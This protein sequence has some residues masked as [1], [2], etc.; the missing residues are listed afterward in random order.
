MSWFKKA[1]NK[2]PRSAPVPAPHRETPAIRRAMEQSKKA[3]ST[4][5]KTE[6]KD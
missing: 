6:R 1:P 2:Y 5:S 4:Q 3:G